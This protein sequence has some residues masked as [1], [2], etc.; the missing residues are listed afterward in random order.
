MDYFWWPAV[1]YYFW[2]YQF[3]TSQSAVSGSHAGWAESAF[4][5]LIFRASFKMAYIS[6]HALDFL[7]LHLQLQFLSYV[8][9]C[10][11]PLQHFRFPFCYRTIT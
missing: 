10:P 4:G 9:P 3:A 8:F 6:T 11:F 7:A 5:A 1:S 2:L